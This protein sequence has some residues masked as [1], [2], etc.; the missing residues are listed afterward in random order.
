MRIG[1]FNANGL[2]GKA[3]TILHFIVEKKIDI[4]IIAETWLKPSA[5]TLIRNT[6][7]NITKP[8]NFILNNGG[9]RSLGGI[10]V[11]C[12]PKYRQALR[13]VEIDQ[14]QD[15]II[16]RI[17]NYII[18]A[19]YLSPSANDAK[20]EQ[21]MTN[22]QQHATDLQCEYVIMGDINARI[23]NFSGDTLTNKRGRQLIQIIHD[24]NLDI[25]KG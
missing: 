9:R 20:L 24:L 2:S 1:F 18:G 11:V 7:I 12:N 25:L 10:M 13:T 14:D 19:A 22:V 15:Y 6:F 21:F 16:L 3:D 17:E 5:S 23:G 8:T 4:F